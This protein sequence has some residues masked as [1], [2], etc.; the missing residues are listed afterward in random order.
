MRF[1]S[2]AT[3]PNLLHALVMTVNLHFNSVSAKSRQQLLIQFLLH[4]NFISAKSHKPLLIKF[5]LHDT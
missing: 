5:P 1:S 3:C 2:G 4:L